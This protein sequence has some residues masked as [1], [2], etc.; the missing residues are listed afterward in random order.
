MQYASQDSSPEG[1]PVPA[2][3]NII[4]VCDPSGLIPSA[5]C[6]NVVDEVFMAGNEPTQTDTLYQRL[7]INRETGQL[8]TVHTQSELI[9]E[10]VYLIVPPEAIEWARHAGLPIPPDSYDVITNDLSTTPNAEISSPEMFAYVRDTVPVTGTAIGDEFNFYRLQV[11]PGLNPRKWLQI[12]DEISTPVTAIQLL[13]VDKEQHVETRTIQVTVD[14]QPPEVE[15]I[16]PSESL[17]FIDQEDSITIQ[18]NIIENIAIDSVDF[19]INNKAIH[20]LRQP[21]FSIPWQAKPGK[22]TLRVVAID[23]AGNEG[24]TTIEFT[25]KE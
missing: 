23:R 5:D 1:W 17:E 21:P 19:Y 20:T 10:R 11:G 2:G 18:V 3:I 12:G 15:I 16:Y 6:P 7:Q 9:E 25:V 4:S 24:R 22:H 13:V 8:A 14:N